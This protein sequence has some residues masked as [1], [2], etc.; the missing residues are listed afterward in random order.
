[1]AFTATA[2]KTTSPISDYV[3]LVRVVLTTD[4][5]IRIGPN[6]GLAATTSDMYLPAGVPEYFA[7]H[8]NEHISAI[9]LS[10]SGTMYVTEMT[11]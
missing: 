4:G 5:F 10:S 1:V 6:S 9:R 11:H 3:F 2:A 8:P 7:V